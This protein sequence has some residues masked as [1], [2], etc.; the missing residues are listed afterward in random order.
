M[1]I[2]AERVVGGLCCK[3]CIVQKC[4]G[5]PIIHVLSQIILDAKSDNL[6]AFSGF[7]DR[8]GASRLK[9]ND[10]THRKYGNYSQLH[11]VLLSYKLLVFMLYNI[12]V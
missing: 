8:S 5:W 11:N 12:V 6:S 4:T 2:C 1:D 7:L 10:P 9:S 3:P